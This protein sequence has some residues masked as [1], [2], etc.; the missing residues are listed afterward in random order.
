MRRRAFTLIELLVVIAIIA[1]LA[2]LLLP[3]LERAR[4]SA[5]SVACAGKTKQLL[6]YLQ[7]YCD[8]HEGYYATYT[9]WHIDELGAGWAG[10]YDV[11]IPYYTNCGFITRNGRGQEYRNRFQKLRQCPSPSQHPYREITPSAEVHDICWSTSV[12][13]R[14]PARDNLFLRERYIFAECWSYYINVPYYSPPSWA[15]CPDYTRHSGA[16]NFGFFDIS[17]HSITEDEVMATPGYLR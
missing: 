1:V 10:W 2:A 9:W 16:S 15:R 6:L 8:D 13:F 5:R 12:N 4:E 11:L 17:V 3:A 14:R 7:F